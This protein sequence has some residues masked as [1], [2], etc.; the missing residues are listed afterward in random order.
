MEK[1]YAESSKSGVGI[2]N[3]EQRIRLYY[4]SGQAG[5]RI[6]SVVGQGTTIS[7]QIPNDFQANGGE[8]NS[9]KTILIVDDEPRTRE[10]VR[11]TLEAWSS[12]RRRI[13]TASSGVEALEWSQDQ[14]AHL[15]VTDIRMPE[16]GDLSSLRDCMN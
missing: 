8:G 3:V 5:L 2:A 15:V 9:M 6:H 10:G 13:V 1:G 4:A 16:I 12:G 14:V 7:F 11:K